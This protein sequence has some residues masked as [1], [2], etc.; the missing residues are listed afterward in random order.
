MTEHTVAIVSFE[1][2]LKREAKRLRRQLRQ[3]ES[4]SRFELEITIEGRL[5]DGDLE[6]KYRIGEYSK[7][8][9]GDSL[10]PVVDE[11]MR[12]HG[13]EQIHSPKAIG[14][15]KIPSDDSEEPPQQPDDPI[16]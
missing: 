4:L 3:V 13:W 6:L 12:R 1:G 5:H 8:V 10:G 11:F 2:A 16:F 15:D 14:Y 9:T 7:A